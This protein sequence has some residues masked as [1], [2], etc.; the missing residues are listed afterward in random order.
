MLT[1][2]SPSS[3]AINVNDRLAIYLF[4]KTHKPVTECAFYFMTRLLKRAPS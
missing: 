1:P 3:Y 2:T 4:I